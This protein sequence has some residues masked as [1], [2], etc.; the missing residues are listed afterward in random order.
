MS[1]TRPIFRMRAQSARIAE[2]P[3]IV[4]LEPETVSWL[5]ED[6]SLRARDVTE[7]AMT[8]H[9]ARPFTMPPRF[10]ADA[11]PG[12]KAYLSLATSSMRIVSPNDMLLY[13]GTMPTT[14]DWPRDVAAAGNAVLIT[15]PMATVA[16]FE[17]LVAEGRVLW[18]RIPFEIRA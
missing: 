9:G 5:G 18:L 4:M 17:T 10:D 8:S 3:V 1:E 14:P 6:G 2:Q 16:D 15:G 11:A 7:L 12:W 13:E